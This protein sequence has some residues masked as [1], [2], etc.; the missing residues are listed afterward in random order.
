MI[1]ISTMIQRLAKRTWK[2]IFEEKETKAI[3]LQDF[4]WSKFDPSLIALDS[5]FIE[6]L[7]VTTSC[8]D[9]VIWYNRYLYNIFFIA[10]NTK[11]HIFKSRLYFVHKK[12]FN[13][14]L[15]NLCKVY[16]VLCLCTGTQVLLRTMV[17]IAKISIYNVY[18]ICI[19]IWVF[20]IIRLCSVIYQA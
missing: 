20:R 17:F 15:I 6:K 11:L 3:D 13:N 8:F 4:F 1:F 2:S 16:P 12:D 7:E 18:Y 14:H 5:N 10:S 19:L 9:V